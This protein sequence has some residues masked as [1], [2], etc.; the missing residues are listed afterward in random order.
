MEALGQVLNGFVD[1]FQPAIHQHVDTNV[2]ETKQ[3]LITKLPPAIQGILGGGGGG[4][5]TRDVQ[6]RGFID[7]MMQKVTSTVGN[8]FENI[9]EK[10]TQIS[11]DQVD[12][13]STGTV[14]YLTNSI[15]TECKQTISNK[16]GGAGTKE[17]SRDIGGE[18]EKSRALNTDFLNQG[19][20][21]VINLALERV[22]PHV[23]QAG[24]DIYNKL[25]E[26]MPGAVRDVLNPMGGEASRGILDQGFGQILE[27]IKQV[28]QQVAGN[29]MPVFE[30][31]VMQNIERELNQKTPTQDMVVGIVQ[32]YASGV[33]IAGINL[34]S[35]VGSLL[36]GGGQGQSQTQ[37]TGFAQSDNNQP[38]GGYNQSGNNQPGG[39]FVQ[40]DSSQPG[41]GGYNQSGNN[42]PSGG[43]VQSD[44][45]QQ[46]GGYGQTGNN[47]PGQPQQQ[48]SQG[49]SGGFGNILGGLI[50]NLAGGQNQQH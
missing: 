19:R 43:F 31:S 38:G 6:D 21:S 17:A 8:V 45:N 39:G 10:L 18:E 14:D 37:N 7:N 2:R 22:R 23:H 27:K 50:N 16:L 11:R 35:V 34:G 4:T 30:N 20:E 41:G 3:E 9:E 48:G 26:S 32:K 24:Q 1:N 46:G 33:N 49:G 15:V 36:G 25:T 12:R 47:Q 44:N 29:I 40:S 13:A 28:V 5:G 42:Q